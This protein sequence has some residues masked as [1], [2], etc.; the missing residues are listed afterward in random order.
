MAANEYPVS[1]PPAHLRIPWWRRALMLGSPVDL[2]RHNAQAIYMDVAMGNIA[3]TIVANFL[4]VLAVRLGAS[5]LLVGALT[6]GPFLIAVFISLPIARLASNTKRLMPNL[7][8]SVFLFRVAFLLFALIP[9][10]F[11]QHRVE[12]L[13]IANLLS[14]IPYAVANVGFFTMYAYAIQPEQRA[15]VMSRRF[16]IG[17]LTA[18]LGLLLAGVWLERSPFPVNYEVMFFICFIISLGSVWYIRRVR[19]PEGEAQSPTP[20]ASLSWPVLWA[21][22]RKQPRFVYFAICGSSMILTTCMLQPLYP[23]ML[24]HRL[25]ASDGWISLL[26]TIYMA[27]SFLAAM[28]VDR[29]IRRWGT[30][31]TLVLTGLGL[32]VYC[33]LLALAPSVVFL[34]PVH[35]FSGALITGFNVGLSHGLVETCPEENRADFT[36]FYLTLVNLVTFAGPLLGSALSTAFG[37]IAAIMIVGVLR[38]AAGLLSLKLK[39]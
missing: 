39:Y 24:V 2:D 28:V 31:Y 3:F 22:L 23:I 16:A 29:A 30:R 5:D 33:F 10:I 18:M 21:Q 35:V 36:A 8:W 32:G 38:A 9:A 37:I 1:V 27:I 6:G 12:A 34:I 25:G 13:V 7:V 20:V 11:S 26:L 17:G 19:L 14:G 15:H 4:P